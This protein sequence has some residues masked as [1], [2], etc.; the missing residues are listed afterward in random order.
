MYSAT[1]STPE[2]VFI[3]QEKKFLIVPIIFRKKIEQYME[4]SMSGG[5]G[6]IFGNDKENFSIIKKIWTVGEEA[7]DSY[8]NLL[9]IAKEKASKA[10]MKLLGMFYSGDNSSITYSTDIYSQEEL[11]SVELVMENGITKEWVPQPH[12]FTGTIVEQKIIL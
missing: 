12:Q 3:T 6:F 4:S 10:G 7:S 5:I 9:K 8:A 1:D 2:P 11:T